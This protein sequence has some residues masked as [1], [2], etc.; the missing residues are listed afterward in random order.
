ML[1]RALTLFTAKLEHA[2]AG[3][4]Q[5]Q[6]AKHPKPITI[7]AAP[8][9][10]PA[11]DDI[12]DA[13]TTIL[14]TI[15]DEPEADLEPRRGLAEFGMDSILTGQA[16]KELNDRF[17]IAL[18]PTDLFNYPTIESLASYITTV[19]NTAVDQATVYSASSHND[20]LA[21]VL[22]EIKTEFDNAD[23]T[24]SHSEVKNA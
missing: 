6:E 15:L 2:F 18:S 16:T 20:P 23:D 3:R 22:E 13:V 14:A 1:F 7:Q 21:K 12:Q 17:G 24:E 10:R 11:P 8:K 19:Q 4:A 9:L 5:T